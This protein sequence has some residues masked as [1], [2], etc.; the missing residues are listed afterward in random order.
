M[1]A[2]E[3]DAPDIETWL[4]M[5]DECHNTK[6][7]NFAEY[8]RSDKEAIANTYLKKYSNGFM[9]GTVNKIKAIKR[10]MFN[11]ARIELLRAKAIYGGYHPL[12]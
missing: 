8:V 1:I 9:E 5:A 6:L 3:D 12:N 2:G 11:R 4:Q 7:S 10:S